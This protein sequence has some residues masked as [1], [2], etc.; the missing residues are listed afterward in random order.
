MIDPSHDLSITRQAKALNIS[1]GSVY[2]KP[3]PVSAEDLTIMRRID[4]LH[5]DYPFAGS[6]M[7]RDMLRR[8]E[9][10]IGRQCVTTLMKRMGIEAHYRRPNTPFRGHKTCGRGR[11]HLSP[12]GAWRK[13]TANTATAHIDR[14]GEHARNSGSMLR[15]PQLTAHAPCAGRTALR[16]CACARRCR[17]RRDRRW[18]ARPSARGDSRARSAAWRRPHR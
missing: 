9:T 14:R 18:C 6:R 15:S 5:L 17:C 1:R 11:G 16:R 3:H 7:L 13:V 4:E 10:P 12:L 2:Y 8:E